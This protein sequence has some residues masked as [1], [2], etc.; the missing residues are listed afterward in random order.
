[1]LVVSSQAG[2]DPEALLVGWIG[3]P[4]PGMAIPLT[5]VSEVHYWHLADIS[6]A[7]MDVC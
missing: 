7:L 6:R 2:F 3:S 1:V 4:L 5:A